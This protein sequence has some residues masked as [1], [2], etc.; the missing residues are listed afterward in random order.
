MIKDAAGGAETCTGCN[1]SEKGVASQT[2]GGVPGEDGRGT[3]Q[4]VNGSGL[5]MCT[6]SGSH[7]I[8]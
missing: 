4:C 1:V 6:A 3:L 5:I 2:A 7:A 8:K